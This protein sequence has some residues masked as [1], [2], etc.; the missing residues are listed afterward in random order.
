MS[1][2]NKLPEDIWKF[3]SVATK[4]R[5]NGIQVAHRNANIW[6]IAR[7][8][9]Y[10]KLEVLTHPCWTAESLC[11]IALHEG[12]ARPVHKKDG[13]AGSALVELTHT[14]DA[15]WFCCCM[16]MLMAQLLHR[17]LMMGPEGALDSLDLVVQM[18][19]RGHVGVGIKPRS[20]WQSSDCSD[21]RTI[22]IQISTSPQ[23]PLFERKS[24]QNFIKLVV[25][26][27]D[28]TLHGAFFKWC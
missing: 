25:C 22:D 18:A 14:Q 26:W 21:T 8:T 20:S 1:L 5:N 4:P 28:N 10:Q 13:K 17:H 15:G 12:S 2:F 6:I 19:G 24:L 11:M 27:P 3:D 7:I 9:L 23:I 16:S